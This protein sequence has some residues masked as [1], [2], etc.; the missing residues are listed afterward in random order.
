M[1]V[2]YAA[3]QGNFRFWETQVTKRKTS[4]YSIVP[5]SEEFQVSFHVREAIKVVVGPLI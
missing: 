2:K 5:S 1:C 4:E 3:L